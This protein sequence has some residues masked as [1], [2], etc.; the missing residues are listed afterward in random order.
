M[1]Q[2]MVLVLIFSRL[3]LIHSHCLTA[4]S[5]L[6]SLGA[7]TTK[8]S[9]FMM[10]LYVRMDSIWLLLLHKCFTGFW[11]WKGFPRDANWLDNMSICWHVLSCLAQALLSF[12]S[13]LVW[14]FFF[15]QAEEMWWKAQLTTQ[16]IAL[17]AHCG[18][19]PGSH[20]LVGDH[21]FLLQQLRVGREE[22][23]HNP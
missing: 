18:E 22:G 13:H 7:Y 14:L 16:N 9:S 8:L 15:A 11:L 10:G 6:G 5:M 4:N 20:P 23:I 12:L 1:G 3:D 17:L 21:S 19:Q 2:L